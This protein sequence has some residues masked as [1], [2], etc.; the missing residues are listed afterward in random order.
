MGV[1]TFLAIDM[2]RSSIA[3]FAFTIVEV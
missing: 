2:K 1:Q 3:T